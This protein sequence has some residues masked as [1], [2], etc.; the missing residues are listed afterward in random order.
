MTRVQ[1]EV[2]YFE[3]CPNHA[4]AVALVHEVVAAH[5]TG[6]QVAEVVVRTDEDARRLHFLGSPSIRVN[7]VDIEPGADA[8]RDYALAC[9]IYGSSGLPERALLASALRAES[10]EG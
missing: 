5:G 2:L 4:L 6:A 8:R 10:D 7:G 3:G 9:R 1:I